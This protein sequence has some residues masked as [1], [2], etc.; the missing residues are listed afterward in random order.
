VR[1]GALPWAMLLFILAALAVAFRARDYGFTPG[2][3][4][5]A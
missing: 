2:A 5:H 3:L 1:A 4:A